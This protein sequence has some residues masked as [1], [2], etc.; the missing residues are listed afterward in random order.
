MALD[1]VRP[2]AILVDAMRERMCQIIAILGVSYVYLAFPGDQHRA[3][4]KQEQREDDLDACIEKGWKQAYSEVFRAV[5]LWA[6]N[7]PEHRTQIMSNFL[8]ACLA[9]KA[10]IRSSVH[11]YQK[12]NPGFSSPEVTAY[13]MSFDHMQNIAEA[14]SIILRLGTRVEQ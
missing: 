7:D 8:S 4:Q 14:H 6:D 3:Q 13:T 1:S 10:S 2:I 5:A 11:Y 9:D 12:E